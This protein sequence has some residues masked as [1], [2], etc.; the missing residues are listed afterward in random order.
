MRVSYSRGCHQDC[1]TK[2][3]I[4]LVDNCKIYEEDSFDAYSD[5]KSTKSTEVPSVKPTPWPRAVVGFS[6]N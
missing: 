4:N 3:A 6:A 2:I 5:K 1:Y